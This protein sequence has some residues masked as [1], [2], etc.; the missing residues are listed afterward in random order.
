[1]NQ[2]LYRKA[3]DVWQDGPKVAPDY[4]D[5]TGFMSNSFVGDFIECEYSAIIKYAKIQDKDTGFKEAFATGHLV[6]AI[7]FEGDEGKD[8]MLER[9]KDNAFKPI[10][11]SKQKKWDDYILAKK[12]KPVL[13]D[14][15]TEFTIDNEPLTKI[16]VNKF[17]KILDNPPEEPEA[18]T[19]AWVDHSIEY[20]ESIMRHD[21]IKRLLQSESSKYHQT[22][23]FNMFGMSW[24]MEADYLNLN[25]SIEVDM[26]TTKASFSDRSWNQSTRS[27]SNTFIDDW[28]Y[29][30]QR[31]VYQYG[32]KSIYDSIVVPHILAVSK[33]NKSVRM[34]KFDDQARLDNELSKLA[35]VADRAKE[36]I[37]GE[38]EPIL[39]EECEQCVSSEK[40]DFVINT[41]SYC[42]EFIP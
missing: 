36:V 12:M 30:R 2:E 29:H 4:H 20:A 14:S 31:A 6:E 18:E 9:Y 21:N 11:E 27:K 16:Q 38:S 3:L 26:K 39:C 1:M 34:F 35:F 33:K 24:R 23:I 19:Y 25:K 17:K 22:L 32:I 37:A 7:C 41:S 15:S 8:K 42:A 28:N 10:P 13:E 5:C 40:V